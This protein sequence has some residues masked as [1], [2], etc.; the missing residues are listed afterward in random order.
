[1]K[2]EDLDL[3]NQ[4]DVYLA[5][6]LPYWIPLKSSDYILPNNRT[7]K[8]RNDLWLVSSN[9]IVDT[10]NDF[11]PDI[12]VNEVQVEDE[13]FLE[14]KVVGEKQYF[15]KRK[16]RTTFSRPLTF[17]PTKRV[18]N[19]PSPSDEW[20]QQ[21]TQA[22]FG[23]LQQYTVIEKFMEDANLFIDLYST[24]ISPQNPSR[25]VRQVSF[26]ESMIHVR[27][28]CRTNKFHFE[29]LTRITPDWKMVDQPHPP[30]R[31]RDYSALKEFKETIRMSP[32]VT[33]HQLEWVKTMNYRR[34]KRYQDA[35]LHA[36][37]TLESLAHQFMS[38]KR[39]SKK[40]RK[41]A[42]KPGLA[43]WLLSLEEMKELKDECD[44]IK[45]LRTLRNNVVHREYVLSE[46]DIQL[47]ISGID[48]LELVR[49][50]LLKIGSPE[51][52]ERE[53]KFSSFLKPLE[54]GMSIGS[55][56]GRMVPMQ[57]RWLKE[58]E[59]YVSK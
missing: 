51:I 12:I 16:M 1:L 18:V 48:C 10:P 49:T 4:T 43:K 23:I 9:N 26:Y 47:V 41:K 38:A 46:D 53:N 54:L 3:K 59:C 22:V 56:V 7:I 36:T 55:N 24:L 6:E 8:V 19:A 20:I 58:K 34:E 30:S 44:T 14:K 40:Q 29:H 37:I 33:F 13:A 57:F 21:H 31:V 17:T 52:L 27:M 32:P 15:H 28:V 42:L 39:F 25:E 35:L 2:T 50:H 11:P 5:I 45:K